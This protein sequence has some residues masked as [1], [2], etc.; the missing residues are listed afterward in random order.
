M[1]GRSRLTELSA[2]APYAKGV[3][4]YGAATFESVRPIA[5]SAPT[6]RKSRRVI[7]SQVV[8]EPFPLTLSIIPWY[9]T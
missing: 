7:P 8:I 1:M 5:P 4:A 6:C 2:V 9:Q 3:F